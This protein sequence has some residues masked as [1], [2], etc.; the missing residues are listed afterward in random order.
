[1]AESVDGGLATAMQFGQ[2]YVLMS[3]VSSAPP[4][5]RRASTGAVVLVKLLGA[6][7]STWVMMYGAATRARARVL[8]TSGNLKLAAG[9][10]YL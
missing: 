5:M 7:S 8:S 2:S 1:V 3:G 4:A 10:G 6:I 9:L